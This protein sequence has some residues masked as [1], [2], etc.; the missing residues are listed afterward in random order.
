MGK[1]RDLSLR[2]TI[3]LYEAIALFTGFLSSTLI[4]SAA[5]K[6]QQ[7]VWMKYMEIEPWYNEQRLL[8]GTNRPSNAE[9]EGGDILLSEICDALQT[10]P[11]LILPLLCCVIAIFLFYRSKIKEPLQILSEGSRKISENNLD[12]QIY[13]RKKDEMGQLCGDFEAMRRQLYDNNRKLWTAV[14]QEKILKAAIAHDIRTPLTVLRGYQ[15]MLL[16]FMPQEKLDRAAMEE[17]LQAGLGQI[18][19]LNEFVE[20]M[21]RLSALEQRTLH[22]TAVSLKEMEKR[23][24]EM[25]EILCRERDLKVIVK[26]QEAAEKK[27]LVDIS[28]LY[29]V[30]EN[31]LTNAIRYAET[32]ISVELQE[33]N[34][35]LLLI[36]RDDG[37]GFKGKEGSLKQMQFQTAY[38]NSA[39]GAPA[40]CRDTEKE[41]YHTGLSEDLK[42]FGLGLYLCN[43]Y[44]ERHGG[45]LLV[46]N[47]YG[48]GACIKAYFQSGD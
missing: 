47:A 33:E 7:R 42:H 43:M 11:S 41:F 38:G 46:G 20:M 15:E 48:G 34:E 18:E 25:A 13:Y 22:Y 12:F 23:M 31:L 8:L 45:K 17:M 3:I 28:I 29:E 40:A 9:M 1:I 21:R 35:Q 2:K 19:R 5:R 30:C 32:V 14:E 26:A 27:L 24:Q 10:W 36:V 4:V 16:E 6:A 44:C 39:A 37:V